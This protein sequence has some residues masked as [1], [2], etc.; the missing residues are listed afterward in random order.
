MSSLKEKR[1]VEEAHLSSQGALT[2]FKDKVIT[3]ADDCMMKVFSTTADD[4]LN[5]QS[6]I[7]MPEETYAVASN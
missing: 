7:D 5:E 4:V 3:V 6:L 2:L 1:V